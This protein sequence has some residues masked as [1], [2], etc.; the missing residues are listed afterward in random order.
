MAVLRIEGRIDEKSV[1]RWPGWWRPVKFGRWLRRY[2]W[3]R[4]VT[5]V[6][7]ATV[8]GAVI[9]LDDPSEGF[10]LERET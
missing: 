1:Q 5:I 6:E 8:I 4:H 3:T 10:E 9:V 7:K 2:G